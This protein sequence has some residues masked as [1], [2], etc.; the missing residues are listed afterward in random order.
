MNNVADCIVIQ[1]HKKESIE[2]G[3]VSRNGTK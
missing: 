3:H 1:T 2:I